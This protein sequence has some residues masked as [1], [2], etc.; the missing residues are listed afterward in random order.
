[1]D[2]KRTN[3]C[4]SPFTVAGIAGHLKSDGTPNIDMT[5]RYIKPGEEEKAGAMEMISWD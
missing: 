5:L 2:Q 4:R 3:S 1:V